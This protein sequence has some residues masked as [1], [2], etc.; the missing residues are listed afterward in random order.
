MGIGLRGVFN[1]QFFSISL[2][3][4]LLVQSWKTKTQFTPERRSQ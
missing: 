2:V 1:K 3:C 4:G